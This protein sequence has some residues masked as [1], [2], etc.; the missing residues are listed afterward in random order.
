MKLQQWQ[1][2][3]SQ[4][5]QESL[6]LSLLNGKKAGY[7]VEIGAWDYK[8]CSNTFLLETEFGWKGIGIEILKKH[9][10]KYNKKRR[11]KCLNIDA[12]SLDY[13][14][15]F[16]D[17]QFPEII[18]YLQLDIDPSVNTFNCL[19]KMPFDQYRFRIITFEHDLY[20]SPQNAIHQEL[21]HHYLE[22]FGYFRIGKNVCYNGLAFEDWYVHSDLIS[23]QPKDVLTTGVNWQEHFR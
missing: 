18:D 5:G 9:A 16:K 3:H 7:Y 22:Q 20:I 17:N 12:L 21:G 11:N 13:S 15:I 6:V 19:L 1:G 2:S 10:R 14:K 8:D 23:I 4:C